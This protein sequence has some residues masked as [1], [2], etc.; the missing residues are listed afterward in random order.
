MET[1]LSNEE[2]DNLLESRGYFGKFEEIEDYDNKMDDKCINC[3]YFN[4]SSLCL[5]LN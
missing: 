4:I 3:P 5:S 2:L 1:L